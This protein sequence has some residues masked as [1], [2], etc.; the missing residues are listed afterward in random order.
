MSPRQTSF[1]RK[2]H[3]ITAKARAFPRNAPLAAPYGWVLKP[4]AQGLMTERM[5]GAHAEGWRGVGRWGGGSGLKKKHSS[6]LWPGKA[7]QGQL[8]GVGEGG[9][10]GG[11]SDACLP[12]KAGDPG[13]TRDLGFPGRREPPPLKAGRLHEFV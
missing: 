3:Q 11:E 10:C 13:Q 6:S 8:G 2:I 12:Q 9:G 4:R 1:L 7:A 5:C